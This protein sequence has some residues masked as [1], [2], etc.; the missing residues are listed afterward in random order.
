MALLFNCVKTFCL[1][2]GL[3]KTYWIGYSGGLDS[4]V[5]LHLC[6]ELRKQYPL[7][8]KAIH[9]HHG[10]SAHA[11]D[12]AMHCEKIC[13]DLQIELVQKSIDAKALSGDSPEEIARERRYAI[14]AAL[15]ASQNILLTA[16]QQDDQ[17]ET[18]LLQ[19]LRGAGPKGLAAMPVLKAFAAGFHGRPLLSIPRAELKQY[20]EEHGLTWI[21]DESNENKKYS[22]N[23]LR[24]AILPVLQQRWPTVTN[25]LA[26]VAKN[27]AETQA[28]VEDLARQDMIACRYAKNALAINKLRSLDALRQRQVLRAW[29]T[30][31]GFEIPSAVKL[32]QIQHDFL[33]AKQDKSP[34]IQLGSV[35]LRRYRDVLYA[36]PCLA[37]HDAT[38]VFSWDLS[39]PL[40]IPSVG[41]LRAS[42]TDHAGLRMDTKQVTVRFRQ[43][44]E[45]CYFAERRCHQS[46]KHLL[47]EWNVPPWERDRLPLLY[48]CETLVA[49]VGFFL[50]GRY[51]AAPGLRLS[52][53]RL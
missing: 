22:R 5:L 24:H 1:A 8:I 12:W 13:T 18:V 14:F 2:Q 26:R 38:Q 17:A 15:L 28:L 3:D 29:L 21:D 30:E 32:R 16:H 37:H 48:V 23:F 42:L 44:G 52:I 45:K 53:N 40:V 10:L 4:H 36:M 11:S 49:V 9:V 25:T 33:Q 43:G 34:Y 41:E 35:E 19:L 31:S 27:C 39:Q 46:L 6:A 20:A 51:A 50:D 7:Q 47:Q